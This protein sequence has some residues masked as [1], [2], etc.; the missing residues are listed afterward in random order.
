MEFFSNLHEPD[1]PTVKCKLDS[2]CNFLYVCASGVCQHKELWPITTYEAFAYLGIFFCTGLFQS[3]GI[4]GG[5]LFVSYMLVV[6]RFDTRSAIFLTYAIILGG[7]I[8]RF[9][10]ISRDKFG[11]T[12]KPAIDYNLSILIIPMLLV[13]TLIGTY[14]KNIFP[15]IG[16][17]MLLAVLLILALAKIG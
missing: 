5:E 6:F 4:G 16:L 15:E 8:G 17:L 9:I 13:G 12:G 11:E 10:K 7:S 14:L 1:P 2:D 3:A